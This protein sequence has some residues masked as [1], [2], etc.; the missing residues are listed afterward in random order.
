VLAAAWI[1]IVGS[2]FVLSILAHRGPLL[3][4]YGDIAQLAAVLFA[5]AGLLANSLVVQKR[6]RVFWILLGLGCAAWLVGQAVWTYFEAILKQNVP[7]PFLGDVIFFLHPVPMIGALALKPHDQRDDLNVHIGYLDFSLLLVWW[8]FLYLFVVIPWQYVAPNLLNYG[9]SYDYL[10]AI[11]NLVLPLGF[12]Y[13]VA[14][15]KG[16]WRQVYTHLFSASLMYL[17][18]SF[19]INKAIDF[20]QYYTGSPYDLL[21]VASFVWFGTAGI[22][23][24]Q[25]KPQR[26]VMASAGEDTRTWVAILS[27]V[28]VFSI[29]VMAIWSLWGSS[30]SHEVSAFRIAV[31]QV[32]LLVVA[33]LIGF[34]QRL[35]DR[36]RLRLL[37]E[38][39]KSLEYLKHFQSQMVQ[40]EKLVSLGQLAA[41]AAHEI[42]NP[43]TGVLGYSD[44]LIDDASLNDRQRA[45]AEKIR[46]LARRIKTLVASLLS[47]ARQVPSEKT[48]LDLNHVL[49]SA[50]HL[51]N[52]DL[53][54]KHIV[55]EN[56]SDQDLPPVVGDANQIL[57]VFFNLISNAVD[58][59]EEIGGGTLVIRAVERGNSVVMEFSDSGPGIKSPQHVFDPFFTTKPVGKGTGLG[60]SICYGIVQE[61]GGHIECFNRPE[62]GATFV[63]AFPTTATSIFSRHTPESAGVK[64]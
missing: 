43:L 19:L 56:H 30:N 63:V 2:Y 39:R 22:V 10:A 23:A 40:S 37:D 14:K 54:N 50:L 16:P 1:T 58:A 25:L 57:Q 44:L 3:T 34:R 59:L 20:G 18:G 12:A 9:T 62:G 52:L 7:N 36:D 45:V 32:T 33:L 46:T 47:F 15:T 26:E 11:E 4:A 48:E 28:A 29:P 51:S 49:S 42:N 8:V 27:M 53:R 24:Y 61:H 55:V 31:T 6:S 17:A 13:L 38:S 5:C 60:L 35:V 64:N 21:V 41:G